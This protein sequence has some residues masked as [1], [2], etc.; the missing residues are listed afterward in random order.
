MSSSVDNWLIADSFAYVFI[1]KRLLLEYDFAAE[2]TNLGS[3]C[4]TLTARTNLEV[5]ID[6]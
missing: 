6:C 2:K 4:P 1:D 3:R 5:Y